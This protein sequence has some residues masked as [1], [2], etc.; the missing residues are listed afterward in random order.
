MSLIYQI[1]QY[2]K[3]VQKNDYVYSLQKQAIDLLLCFL[4]KHS[5]RVKKDKLD[6]QCI[7]YF[8][9]V[10]IPKYK[11]YLS[12]AEAYNLVY[13]IQDIYHFI[14]QKLSESTQEEIEEPYILDK[15]GKEYLRIYKVRRL[16]SQLVGDPVLTTQPLVIDLEAYR[17]QKGKVKKRDNMSLYEQGFFKV[18]EINRDGY[19]TLQKLDTNKYFK[20]LFRPSY[21]AH[22]KIGDL[23]NGGLK[24]KIFF[25]YW[26][27]EDIKGYYLPQALAYLS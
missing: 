27:L 17:H 26:E 24:K 6:E 12:E 7:D 3:H 11:K 22:F 1:N 25:I 16:L 5:T 23:L 9:S 8:L 18:T 2:E 10:W 15:Y 13:T 4:S 20:V 19:I 21:L 14:N